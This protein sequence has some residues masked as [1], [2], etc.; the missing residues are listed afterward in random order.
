MDTA[1]RIKVIEKFLLDRFSEKTVIDTTVQRTIDALIESEGKVSINSILG[2]DPT[3]RRQLERLFGK[4]VGISPKKLGRVIRLQSIL[5]LLLHD[6]PGSLTEIAY[7]GAYFDQAHF[8]KDFKE[9]TGTTP[10]DFLENKHLKL[11]ALLYK[12]E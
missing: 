12:K 8:I 3:R 10:G 4:Q 7:Q 5:R 6:E 1:Q 11:S 2:N 9:F